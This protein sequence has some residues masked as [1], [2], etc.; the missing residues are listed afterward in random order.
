MP[1][2]ET[3]S[4]EQLDGYTLTDADLVSVSEA[5]ARL[6]AFVASDETRIGFKCDAATLNAFRIAACRIVGMEPDKHSTFKTV[7]RTNSAGKTVWARVKKGQSVKA[8]DE[9]REQTLHTFSGRAKREGVR[10]LRE[11]QGIA[12]KRHTAGDGIVIVGIT[13]NSD[14]A[15]DDA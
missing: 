15:G 10:T 5:Y 8:S 6:V 1:I 3:L 7:K 9:T 4:M 11:T 13:R 12:L 14:D 2:F